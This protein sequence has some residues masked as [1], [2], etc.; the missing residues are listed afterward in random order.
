MV[1]A[2]FGLIGVLIGTGI[3]VWLD[4]RRVKRD[5]AAVAKSEARASARRSACA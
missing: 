3:T 4:A 1:S 5:A 2:I